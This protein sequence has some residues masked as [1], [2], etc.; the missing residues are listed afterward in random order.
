MNIKQALIKNANIFK[1][2]KII[3]AALDSEI[4]LSFVLKKPKEFLY[5]YPEKKLNK[6]EEKKLN[7]LI[8]ERKKFIP[9]AYILK[10]QDFFGLNFLVDKNVLI[11]RPETEILVEE[12]I[13]AINYLKKKDINA[14][15]IGTGSGAIAISLAKNTKAKI[16]A[17]DISAKALRIA[18]KNAKINNVK[19]NFFKGDLLKPLLNKRI[20]ILAANLPYID[21][22]EAEKLF[23]KP[24]SKGL[25]YEPK[26]ALFAKKNGLEIYENLFKQIKSL[27]YKPKYIL[28]EIGDTEAQALKKIIIKNLGKKNIYIIKDL[29]GKNRVEKIY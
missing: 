25:K 28:I 3:S 24:E 6:V 8:S 11:P 9:I 27:K 16:F 14:A 5:T 17:T 29:C 12:T 10:N 15:D 23:A 21:K 20:D 4:L 18:R 26:N 22:K 2:A 13:N 7:K 1:K 19:I